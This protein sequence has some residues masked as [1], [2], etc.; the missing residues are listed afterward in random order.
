MCHFN[1]P[2]VWHDW[3]VLH[4]WHFTPET[5]YVVS[6]ICPSLIQILITAVYCETNVDNRQISQKGKTREG[7]YICNIHWS[8][9]VWSILGRRQNDGLLLLYLLEKVLMLPITFSGKCRFQQSAAIT[10]TFKNTSHS[11]LCLQ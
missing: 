4:V 7:F 6:L 10:L 8:G 3:H 1:L 2:N 5:K 11:W 9:R